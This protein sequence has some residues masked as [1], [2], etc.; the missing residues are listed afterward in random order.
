[1]RNLMAGHAIAVAAR[2]SRS[3]PA[4]ERPFASP[5]SEAASH[6]NAPVSLLGVCGATWGRRGAALPPDLCH[7]MPKGA[8]LTF[9]LG[10]RVPR[11]KS[12][13]RCVEDERR[14]ALQGA[15]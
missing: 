1:M 3:G 6:Q 7:E 12:P 14:R 10:S 8:A 5:L 13:L 15:H 11:R 2:A 9:P 4:A